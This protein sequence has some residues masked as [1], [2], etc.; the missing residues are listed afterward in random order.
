MLHRF[1]AI[2]LFYKPFFAGSFAINIFLVIFNPYIVPAIIT[3]L[4]LTLLVW[5]FVRETNSKQKLIFYKNLGIS[6]FRLFAFIFL[7][8]SFIT[9]LFLLVMKEFI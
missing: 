1:E 5:F 7:I 6:N 9:V 2:L 4:V 8:D 3:K